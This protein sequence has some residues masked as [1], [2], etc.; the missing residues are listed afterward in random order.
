MPHLNVQMTAEMDIRGRIP[1]YFRLHYDKTY[2]KTT[3]QNMQLCIK[4]M[5]CLFP[6]KHQIQNNKYL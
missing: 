2:M 3:H 5:Y 4:Y 6:K 1:R